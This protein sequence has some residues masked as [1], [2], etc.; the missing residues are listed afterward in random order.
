MSYLQPSTTISEMGCI[1]SKPPSEPTAS[2]AGKAAGPK[3]DGAPVT[4]NAQ[5]IPEVTFHEATP[6]PSRKSTEQ[7]KPD[8]KKVKDTDAANADSSGGTGTGGAVAGAVA[9]GGTGGESGG[10]GGGGG[11]D[12]GGG[13]EEGGG[14]LTYQGK[15]TACLSRQ[16]ARNH[17]TRLC[18]MY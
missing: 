17:C 10:G 8:N 9:T 12:G 2:N 18:A 13:E 1:P 11:G 14:R 3:P 16:L 7:L 5:Q 6:T 4:S 15:D